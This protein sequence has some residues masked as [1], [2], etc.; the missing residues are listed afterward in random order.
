[1]LS[2]VMSLGM[3]GEDHQD[4][5]RAQAM[6]HERKVDGIHVPIDMRLSIG[7]NS[8]TFDADPHAPGGRNLRAS[9]YS[10][11]FYRHNE[12]LRKRTQA[13][14]GAVPKPEVASTVGLAGAE[15]LDALQSP[16]MAL[17]NRGPYGWN[18]PLD[19]IVLP[20]ERFL[21]KPECLPFIFIV[22]AV[23][24][25]GTSVAFFYL[26]SDISLQQVEPSH[27]MFHMRYF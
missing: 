25:L 10:E 18:D 9:G 26:I 21:S 12:A 14:H 22:I 3:S 13:N 20:M 7:G 8:T 27:A 17:R 16:V 2:R 1:M 4:Q 5:Q 15:G 19:V 24:T 6:Q 23:A 11:D